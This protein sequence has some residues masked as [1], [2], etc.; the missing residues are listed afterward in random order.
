MNGGD[1][2]GLE[3]KREKREKGKKSSVILSMVIAVLYSSSNPSST[4]F[5]G[6]PNF[7]LMVGY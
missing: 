1:R 3:K 4:S 7:S 2:L 6:V 5:T